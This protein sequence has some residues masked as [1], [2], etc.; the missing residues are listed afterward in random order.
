MHSAI[1]TDNQM[2]FTPTSAGNINIQITWN[3]NVLAKE[4][5]PDI[6]P[7]FNDVKNDDAVICDLRDSTGT[8]ILIT[9]TKVQMVSAGK[10]TVET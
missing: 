1:G 3:N 4:I 7:L 10:V 5:T 2:P 9:G 6:I 8:G